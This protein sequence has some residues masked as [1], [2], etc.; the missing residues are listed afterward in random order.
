MI[1][2]ETYPAGE[3]SY[4]GGEYG[5][6]TEYS[7]ENGLVRRRFRTTSGGF[8]YCPTCG[9]FGG[10]WGGCSTYHPEEEEDGALISIER[11]VEEIS[12]EVGGRKPPEEIRSD[13]LSGD[14]RVYYSLSY[15]RELQSRG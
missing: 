13:L 2:L 11:A 8:F 10:V 5:F 9:V 4:D 3:K 15:E 7:P 1:V 14:R 12:S 6:W